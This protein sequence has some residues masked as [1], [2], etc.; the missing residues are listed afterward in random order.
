M[1]FM[2]L[3]KPDRE[4]EVGPP[5]SG[6]SLAAMNKYIEERMQA[7]ELLSTEGLLPSSR[8]ARVRLSG[9][10]ITV[11][12]GPFAEAK[13]LVGGFAIVEAGS[14]ADAIE[15]AKRFLRFAG[16]GEIEAR[17]IAE[18]SDFAH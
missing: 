9:G 7:G 13:E 5:P 10:T 18:M 15:M 11:I 6:E 1:R 4:S 8:G 12:D 3:Y 16:D 2:M 14:K 17:Q